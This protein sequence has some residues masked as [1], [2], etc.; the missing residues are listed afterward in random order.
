MSKNGKSKLLTRDQ[1]L[2]S[3]DLPVEDVEIPEWHGTVR[4][5][6]MTVAER[7]AWEQSNTRTFK[8]R[9]GQLVTEA[10]PA[11]IATFRQRLVARSVVDD[12]GNLL[13][14]DADVAALERKSSSAIARIVTVANRLSGV[15]REVT[16]ELEGNSSATE[17]EEPSS[18]SPASSDAPSLN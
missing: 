10:N 14:S 11:A 7:N 3:H 13:F 1:I 2:G 17:A 8:G 15:T 16:E 4:V 9:N 6:G 5:R 12:A 18:G